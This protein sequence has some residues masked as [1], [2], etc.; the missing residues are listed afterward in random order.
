[1]KKPWPRFV[2][3]L[4]AACVAWSAYAGEP[5]SQ[6]SPFSA[7]AYLAHIKY[8]ASE[9]LSGRLT[10]TEGNALAGEY[11]A[12][13]FADA[14]LKPAGENGT[15]FQD[16]EVQRGKKLVA[17]AAA[18]KVDGLDQHWEVRKD[19]IPLPFTAP[20][21]VEG[22][23][24][25]AGYGI[26]A[27][28]HNY[29]DYANFDATGKVLLVLRYEPLVSD[30]E[31]EFG[32]KTPSRYAT[33]AKKAETAAH[34]GAKALLIVN[35]P[36]RDGREGQEDTLFAFDEDLAEQTYDLPLVHVTRPVA[37]ALLKKGGLPDLAS[38]QEQLDRER[39]PLSADLHLHAVLKTGVKPNMIPA[40]NVLGLLPGNGE[41]E[42]MIVL[43]AHYDHLGRV[44]T[45]S[46]SE[47]QTPQIHYGADDNASGTAAV[48]ELARVLSGEPKLRRSV[49]FIT[50][51]AEE[52]GLLG[53]QHFVAHPTV[54]L[55]QVKA[56]VNFDMVG[57]LNAEH[58]TVY[59]L[60][61]GKE[62]GELVDRAALQAGVRYRAPQA[63]LFE[64]SDHASFYQHDIP[65]LFPFT[66]IHKQYH[67]PQDTWQLIDADGAVKILTMFHQIAR[68]L[69]NLESG[70]TFEKVVPQPENEDELPVKPAVEHEKDAREK[71]ERSAPAESHDHSDAPQPKAPRVRLGVLPDYGATGEPGLVV[72]SVVEGGA[73]E[74][75]GM[76]DGDRIVRIGDQTVKDIYGY[77]NALRERKPGDMVDVVVVRKDKGENKEVA[78]KVTLK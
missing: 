63:G 26:Q 13:H 78:L 70:P 33:F 73:A 39:K 20:D 60:P 62:F 30:P 71:A 23:L 19:W 66:G 75:A 35:P 5:A 9:E 40:R 31:A 59:G 8:L 52:L 72:S 43:G 12:R 37:E 1:V 61:S 77:M 64:A 32:G 54:K 38:L 55:E 18:L 51:S 11:I 16:F 14:G 58:F 10:G 68:D 3:V 47:D 4:V 50:F 6:P 48:L 2:F 67:T 56:M 21:D 34:K 45:H 57:R 17:S 74:A 22:P 28:T 36:K 65:V 29:D 69:G 42:E 25:F 24:A 46:D 27:D 15:Y 44:P 41:S 49:L 76:Q 7:D 53:S